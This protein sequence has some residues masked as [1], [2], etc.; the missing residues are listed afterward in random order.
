MTLR[1]DLTC[2]KSQQRYQAHRLTDGRLPQFWLKPEAWGREFESAVV[3]INHD[4]HCRVGTHGHALLFVKN[5]ALGAYMDR[6]NC[7][8]YH[9]PFARWGRIQ[10]SDPTMKFHHVP[11]IRPSFLDKPVTYKE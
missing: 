11:A 10:D 3:Y 1:K 9:E 5:G 8:I 4:A 6:P 7:T 2:I